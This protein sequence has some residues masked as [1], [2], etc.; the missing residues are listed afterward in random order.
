MPAELVLGLRIRNPHG[1]VGCERGHVRDEETQEPT[2]KTARIGRV[3]YTLN[4]V[5][6][7]SGTRKVELS[8]DSAPYH[9]GK[10]IT[11]TALFI[12]AA[13]WLVGALLERRS[14]V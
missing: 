6:L 13:W 8:F 12:S 11:L 3:Y 10:A 5:E 4:G 1:R 7:P 2:G 14:R 9:T